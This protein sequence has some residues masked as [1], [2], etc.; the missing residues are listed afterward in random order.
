[1]SLNNDYGVLSIDRSNVFNFSYTFQT[2][3]PIKGNRILEYAV[4]GWNI[5][6][7]TT[8]QSGPDITTLSS[9]NLGLGG[10][11]PQYDTCNPTRQWNRM[12]H[13]RNRRSEL[14][15]NQQREL[16]ADLLPAIR[17]QI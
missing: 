12:G 9:T 17:L 5:S 10:S 11:G 2:G 14:A 8:W 16:A 15:G 4:N 1:M 13:L 7:I 6:G 3:N